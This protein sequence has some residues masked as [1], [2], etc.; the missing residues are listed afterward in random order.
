MKRYIRLSTMLFSLLLAVI[1]TSGITYFIVDGYYLGRKQNSSGKAISISNK[2]NEVISVIDDYFIGSYDTEAVADSAASG[3]ID[4]LGDKWS[5]YMT[6]DE[7][8][9]YIQATNNNYSGIGIV[10]EKNDSGGILIVSVYEISPASKAGVSAGSVIYG[11]DG[12]DITD[13]T[14]TQAKTIILEGINSGSVELTLLQ[15]DGAERT[16]K[17]MPGTVETNPVSYQMLTGNIGLVTVSNFEAK[18]ARQFIDAVDDLITKGAEGLIFD[19]RVNPGGRLD[20]LLEVLDYLLP[21]GVLFTYNSKGEKSYSYTSGASC[22]DLPMA[23]LVNAETYSAAEFFAAA[24]QEYGWAQIVGEQTT[25][26]GYAQ[27][28]RVL[29]DGSAIHISSKEYF[30]PGGVSLAQTGVTPDK[31]IILDPQANALLY[32]GRLSHADDLQLQAALSL[33]QELFE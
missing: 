31:E 16:V 23:V 20:E 33:V 25:G 12:T 10:I 24:L 4:G 18:C 21:E 26:K 13:Y 8:A 28:T 14:L 9:Q 2:V 29:S 5:Y 30:T 3:M 1:F 6:A 11:V 27:I 32:Y 17:L 15:P 7:Y 22:V 19:M